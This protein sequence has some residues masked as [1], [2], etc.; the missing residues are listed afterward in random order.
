[1]KLKAV[2]KTTKGKPVNKKVMWTSSNT[3]YATVSS[4][5][6]VKALKAGKGKTVKITATAMD[7][8]DCDW[9]VRDDQAKEILK[10]ITNCS[11]ASEF[12]LLDKPTRKAYV[13]ELYLKNLSMG[14]IAELTGMPKSTIHLITK[15]IDPQLLDE[16]KIPRFREDE[17]E[18]HTVYE[19][20]W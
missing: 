14:Q 4:S 6:K 17:T 13:K 18:F 8:A 7:E 12:Q 3:K 11:S 10:T 1:M 20:I 2:V 15:G 16:R 19:E 9:R 5:G